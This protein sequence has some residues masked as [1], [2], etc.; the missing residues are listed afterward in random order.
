M[1]YH[2]CINYDYMYFTDNLELSTSFALTF[3]LKP[4]CRNQYIGDIFTVE[5][6]MAVTTS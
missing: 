4:L 6:R 1:R 2:A 3:D 5:K